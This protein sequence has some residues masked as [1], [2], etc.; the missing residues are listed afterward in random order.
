MKAAFH[1]VHPCALPCGRPLAVQI[2]SPADLPLNAN[3]AVEAWDHAG[4]DRLFR[5]C[6]LAY[7]RHKFARS[8]FE[9]V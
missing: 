4:L 8:G 2:G 6:G 3:V 5:Y 7:L 9:R 1:D